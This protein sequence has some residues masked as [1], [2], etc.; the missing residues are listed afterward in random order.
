MRRLASF[1]AVVLTAPTAL[2]AGEAARAR[3]TSGRP[4]LE[5]RVTPPAAFSPANVLVVARLVGGQDLEDFYCPALEWDF[6][7]GSRSTREGDCPPFDDDTKM[8]RLFSLRYRYSGAG[9]YQ[10][11]LTLRRAGRTVVSASVPVKV[12]GRGGE[13]PMPQAAPAADM[14][15]LPR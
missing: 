2:L 4:Q 10:I 7:D 8:A 3:E 12:L 14:A 13:E 15:R 5:L 6:G 11:R 9:E 1:V